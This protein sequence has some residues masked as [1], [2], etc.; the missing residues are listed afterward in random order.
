MQ[1][2]IDQKVEG[3]EITF[4]PKAH[5]KAQVIDLMEALKASLGEEEAPARV[6][7]ATARKPAKASPRGKAAAENGRKRA[8]R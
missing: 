6:R 1:E 3:E 4:A 7:G 2:V 8:T 5:P